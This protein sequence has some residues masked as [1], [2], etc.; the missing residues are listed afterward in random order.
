M[1]KIESHG[2]AMNYLSDY[3]SG[4]IK[5]G[6]G[7][8]CQLDD[9]MR[10][11]K[12]ELC[13]FLG[14]DGVGKTYV[15]NWFFLCHVLKNKLKVIMWSGENQKGQI[16][17]DLIQMTAGKPFKE[18]DMGV[19]RHLQNKLEESFIF[20]SNKHLYKPEEL[21]EIFGES[22]ADLCLID[23]FTGMDREMG[24]EANYRFL[25]QARHFVNTTGKTMFINTHPVSASG[26]AGN[27]FTEG[28]FKGCLKPPNRSD[29]EGGKSFLNR[30]DF[31]CIIHRFTNHPT[32][33]FH[34]ML[35]VEKVKDTETGGAIS[36][37]NSPLLAEYNFG[38]G[39][40]ING[41]DPLDKLRPN[42]NTIKKLNLF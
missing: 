21:I 19:I 34:T 35:S 4:R 5:M 40:K 42:L 3:H 23:P 31:L 8:G 32:M 24:Y 16:L 14:H 6:L 26:R 13:L 1:N 2:S 10:V 25:N 12:S 11:K 27:F 30:A 28:D 15:I 17:R 29:I 33:K 41:V 22:E 20:I 36:E 18:L 39:M 38:M 7:I 9:F 37:L